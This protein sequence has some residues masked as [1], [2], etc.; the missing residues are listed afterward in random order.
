MGG[1]QASTLA[2]AGRVHEERPGALTVA[3]AVFRTT[4]A[5]FCGT[6]F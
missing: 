2:A 4:R 3:D 6:G 1:V 5:P